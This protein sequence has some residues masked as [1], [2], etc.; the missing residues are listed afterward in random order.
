MAKLSRKHRKYVNAHYNVIKKRQ[1]TMH[2]FMHQ[3]STGVLK[4]CLANN[5]TNLVVGYNKNWK[6]K[7]NLGKNTN[8]KF[9]K[10]PFRAF[11][12]MLFYKCKDNGI[13]M[14]ESNESYTSKCDALNNESVG[15]HEEYS[16]NR[17]KRGLFVSGKIGSNGKKSIINAD[18]NGAVNILRKYISYHYNE[19]Y[20]SLREIIDNTI[21]I[22]KSPLKT[23]IVRLTHTKTM[24]KVLA[25][26]VVTRV[27]DNT[28]V[29][30]EG[31]K[32][33]LSLLI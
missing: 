24:D 32:T 14:V 16:G 20:D 19:L 26:C 18:V 31:M 4:Y 27:C 15:F 25:Q 11:V 2:N 29:K 21:Q 33:I 6:N 13:N 17:T 12:N 28:Q 7:V 9:Y 10:I 23:N 8:D 30:P 1:H 22:I 5:I 3:A